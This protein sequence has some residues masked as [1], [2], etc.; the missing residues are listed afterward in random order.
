MAEEPEINILEEED[1]AEI[2]E[3]MNDG[4]I[5]LIVVLVIILLALLTVAAYF[6]VNKL[7]FEKTRA[8][9]QQL[10]DSMNISTDNAL[11]QTINSDVHPSGYEP[12]GIIAEFDDIIVN[13]A[14]TEGRRYLVVTLS[15]EVN[16][17]KAQ[18]ELVEKTPIIRDALITLLTAKT[19][20]YLSDV[21]NM[22]NLRQE[23]MGK[24]NGYLEKG[25][26]IRVYFTGYVLQ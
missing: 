6:T 26:V 22:E 24:T 12:T 3:G 14:G 25:K 11:I 16:R 8:E 13:P 4:K 23:I 21:K 7:F 15:M 18:D 2:K 17:K 9:I 20:D 10:S 5:A 1:R 19:I